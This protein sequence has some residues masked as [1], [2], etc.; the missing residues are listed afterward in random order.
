MFDAD[1][2]ETELRLAEVV[3]VF[4]D[5]DDALVE[6]EDACGPRGVLA[7]ERDVQGAGD[8]GGGELRCG[9]RVKDDGAFALEAKDLWGGGAVGRWGAGRG[10]T[11]PGD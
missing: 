7:G 5:E 4:A 8:V 1:A 6:A 2:G 9:A 11:R 3:G 10:R